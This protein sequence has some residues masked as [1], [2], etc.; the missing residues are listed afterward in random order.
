MSGATG[1]RPSRREKIKNSKNTAKMATK[2]TAATMPTRMPARKVEVAQ[3]V[4]YAPTVIMSP[5]A[6]FG[7]F[8]TP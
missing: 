4:K 2:M 6:K 1:P 8:F 5:W 7:N 3:R